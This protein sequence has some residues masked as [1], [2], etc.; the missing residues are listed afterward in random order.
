MSII[1]V[2]VSSTIEELYKLDYYEYHY[3]YCFQHD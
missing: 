1:I 2:T 3:C